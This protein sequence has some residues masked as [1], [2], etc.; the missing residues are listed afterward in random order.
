MFAEVTGLGTGEVEEPRAVVVE[1]EDVVDLR[2]RR[3]HRFGL[4]GA[5]EVVDV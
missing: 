4:P 3:G 2:T 5:Q 1:G